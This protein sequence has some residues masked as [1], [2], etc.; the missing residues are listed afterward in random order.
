VAGF[1]VAAEDFRFLHSHV[2]VTAKQGRR[3]TGGKWSRP[4]ITVVGVSTY[5]YLPSKYLDVVTFEVKTS[6]AIDVAA[7]YEALS[8]RRASTRSYVLL[9]VPSQRQDALSSDIDDLCDEAE[10]HGIGVIVIAKPDDYN[11]WDVRVSATRTDPNPEKL[12]DFIAQQLPDKAKADLSR[13]L[14]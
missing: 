10:R 11:T 3:E 13:A 8:H 4:D 14:R 9:H 5:P 1:Q 7:V 6:D 12:S 2:E